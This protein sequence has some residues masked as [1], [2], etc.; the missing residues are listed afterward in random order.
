MSSITTFYCDCCKNEM[1]MCERFDIKMESLTI[2][3]SGNV[4][5]HYE[6]CFNC[7]YEMLTKLFQE[8]RIPIYS[9]FGKWVKEHKK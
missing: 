7:G 1:S 9:W 5:Y 4:D 3:N 6:I 8:K 2:S